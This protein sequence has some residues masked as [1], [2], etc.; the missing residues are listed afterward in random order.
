MPTMLV[1]GVSEN[2]A[3]AAAFVITP[4]AEQAYLIEG[5]ASDQAQVGA[6]G[7]VADI[8]VEMTDLGVHAACIAELDPATMPQKLGRNKAYYIDP[9]HPLQIRNTAAGAADIAWWGH[10][11]DPEIVRTEIYTAPNVGLTYVDIRPPVGEVWLITEIGGEN[12]HA[13][14]WPDV[15]VLL[16]DGVLVAAILVDGAHNWGQHQKLNWVISNDLFL[17]VDPI[18]AAD[19]DIAISAIRIPVEFFGAI[20]DLGNGANVDIAPPLDTSAIITTL[21]CETWGNTGVEAAPNGAPDVTLR[22]TSAGGL[23]PNI[24]EAG[25]VTVATES[26]K[27]HAT[28][29][30]EIDDERYLNVLEVSGAAN[31]YAYSGYLRREWNA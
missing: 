6:A 27:G 26:A 7:C 28:M 29:A 10:R 16:T 14:N 5:I 13:N 17:R 12:Q 25:T 15:T 19:C 24:L 22:M 4:P 11:V 30:I 2:V 20:Q 21:A 18:G 3:G 23:L 8:Q 9:L 31:E 1:H